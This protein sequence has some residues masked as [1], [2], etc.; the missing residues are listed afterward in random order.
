M[1]QLDHYF[2]IGQALVE[3][4]QPLV[5]V[6]IHDT[7]TNNIIFIQGALSKRK[8]GDP[9]LLDTQLDKIEQ[10]VYS[11]MNFDGRLIKSLS[12]PIKE[13]NKIIALMCINYDISLFQDLNKLVGILV[14][15]PLSK[16]PE[17]LFKNDWQSRINEFIAAEL[18]KNNIRFNDLTNKDKKKIVY[19]LFE[20]GA[21]SEKNSVEHVAK[22][23]DM[24]RA[25]VFNY[26][27][28]FKKDNHAI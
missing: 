13:N 4:F 20:L 23:M 15:K 12:I 9:S 10:K 17:V 7:K 22:I 2:A 27:R 11:K 24:G 6:V 25:T 18:N 26:L 3:L 21:F 8:V 5:E 16:K 28:D 1:H 19:R 14:D